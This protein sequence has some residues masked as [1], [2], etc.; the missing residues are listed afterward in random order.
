MA[1]LLQSAGDFLYDFVISGGY[2][3]GGSWGG[4]ECAK[5]VPKDVHMKETLAWVCLMIA[6]YIALG[7]NEKL[8]QL[9][10]KIEEELQ[11]VLPKRNK[12][13]RYLDIFLGTLAVCNWC[14]VLMYKINIKSLI[15]LLQPCHIVLM[16]QAYAL[17]SN[18]STGVIAGLLSLPM[19]TGSGSALLFPDTS[20][21][22][23]YFEEPALVTTLL[24]AE[25]SVVSLT[26]V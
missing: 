10:I 24:C 4:A 21:L 18:S 23:Q 8:V 17:L 6:L 12:A 20:G 7:F 19:V 11:S 25:H 26:S 13:L 2:N 9:K 22:D 5:F 15:N 16:A 14:L 1:S 3:K